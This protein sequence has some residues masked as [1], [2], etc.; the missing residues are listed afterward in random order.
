MIL[1]SGANDAVSAE[2]ARS[3]VRVATPRQTVTE[4]APE[5]KPERVPEPKPEPERVPEL[6]PVTKPIEV[7]T[8]EKKETMAWKPKTIAGKILKGAVIGGGTILGIASG[9]GA[10]AGVV[11]GA[12]ALAGAVSGVSTVANAAVKLATGGAK[13]VGGTLSKVATGAINLVTGTTAEE[14][15]QVRE[16]KAETKAAED[17]LEQV[18][19]LVRAGATEAK[20]RQ[21]A[22]LTAEELPQIN[23]VKTMPQNN[24]LLIYGGLGLAAIFLLPKILKR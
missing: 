9:V 17:K 14:R 1:K 4:R 20:A 6:K 12:G 7:V 2:R 15:K 13:V 19:R 18:Q 22:G 24:N 5:P 10:V 3:T 16:V 23:G 11:G 8:E 21:M